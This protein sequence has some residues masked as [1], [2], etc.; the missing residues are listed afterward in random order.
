[1]SLHHLFV[2]YLR[3]RINSWLQPEDTHAVWISTSD[4]NRII[5]AQFVGG[6]QVFPASDVPDGVPDDWKNDGA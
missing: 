6:R 1:M 3:Q 2:L 4:M 5:L